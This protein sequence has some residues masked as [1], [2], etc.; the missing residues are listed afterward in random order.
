M[1]READKIK[2]EIPAR[3]NAGIKR[4]CALR[5]VRK[6]ETPGHMKSDMPP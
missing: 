5:K 2:N 1:K 6:I 3:K 4:S